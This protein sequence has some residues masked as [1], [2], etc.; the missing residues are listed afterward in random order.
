MLPLTAIG[1]PANGARSPGTTASAA[2]KAFS[3]STSMKA[4]SCRIE[5]LDAPQRGLH[6][7]ARA[8]VAR[9]HQGGGLFGRDERKIVHEARHPTY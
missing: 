4:L 3:A 8:R 1:T 7:L 2:S 5:R 9:A 6:D